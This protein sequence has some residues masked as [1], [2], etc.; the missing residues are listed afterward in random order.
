MFS[1]VTFLMTNALQVV[2]LSP[3]VNVWHQRER[4]RAFKDHTKAIA[5]FKG[6]LALNSS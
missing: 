1:D 4:Q 2:L 5:W 6:Q 3:A